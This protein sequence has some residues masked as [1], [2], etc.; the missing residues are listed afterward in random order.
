MQIPEIQNL[1]SLSTEVNGGVN[2]S[3][4]MCDRMYDCTFRSESFSLASYFKLNDDIDEN[5]KQYAID[6]LFSE[7][8]SA[9]YSVSLGAIK[10]PTYP[11]FSFEDDEEQYEHI[12][13]AEMDNYYNALEE[14]SHIAIEWFKLSFPEFSITEN[15]NV[16]QL[17]NYKGEGE[18]EIMLH[19]T[20]KTKPVFIS[21]SQSF[22][23]VNN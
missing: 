23:Q 5:E 6:R 2:K 22:F 16:V 3:I 17:C 19:E 15:T 21:K 10:K 7:M 13:D 4:E 11:V 18:G 9:C 14:Y 12:V 1:L 20:N 8:A